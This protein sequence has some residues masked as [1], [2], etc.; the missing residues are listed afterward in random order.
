MMLMSPDIDDTVNSDL[1]ERF[2]RAQ[3]SSRPSRGAHRASTASTS[4]PASFDIEAYFRPPATTNSEAA[5][6]QQPEFPLSSE[7]LD[8]ERAQTTGDGELVDVGQGL[9]PY[10]VDG[11]YDDKDSYLRTMYELLREDTIRPLREIIRQVRED[12]HRDE[13]EYESTNIGIYDSVYIKALVFS[14]RGLA[15]RISFSLNRVK[16]NIKYVSFETISLHY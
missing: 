3:L 10:K 2:G 14:N 4:A 8:D 16:K 11:P 7:V 5:W 9:H 6:L 13:Q 15:T 12:P 1:P